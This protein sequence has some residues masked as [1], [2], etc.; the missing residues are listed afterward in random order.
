MRAQELAT[1][2]LA[3]GS[4]L[5]CLDAVTGEGIEGSMRKS[6]VRLTGDRGERHV[7][8]GDAAGKQLKRQVLLIC[9][10][11]RERAV[12]IRPWAGLR[13]PAS[14]GQYLATVSSGIIQAMPGCGRPFGATKH[15]TMQPITASLFLH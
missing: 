10:P 6:A 13:N 2:G 11:L 4:P 14:G 12:R 7:L 9:C 3:P 15:A 8:C 5:A 1:R